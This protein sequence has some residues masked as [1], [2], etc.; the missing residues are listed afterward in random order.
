ML[1]RVWEWSVEVY[2]IW[3][4]SHPRA[5]IECGYIPEVSECTLFWEK[6]EEGGW[7]GWRGGVLYL[8][9]WGKFWWLGG[10]G[11]GL[12]G[13][14]T[15]FW[16]V[17]LVYRKIMERKTLVVPEFQSRGEEAFIRGRDSLKASFAR[18]IERRA[19]MCIFGTCYLEVISLRVWLRGGLRLLVALSSFLLR[20][21]CFDNN[22][23]EGR[24]V[25][26]VKLVLRW[27]GGGISVCSLLISSDRE[28]FENLF[29]VC[30]MS[31][32]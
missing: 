12:Q 13:V 19:P 22:D 9:T 29:Y 1:V 3:Y 8:L 15:G 16:L 32:F 11:K 27:D 21:W 30:Q 28:D 10:T 31:V 23:V 18:D 26:I 5:R 24:G 7:K 17:G 20:W 6:I 25:G 4:C 2:G 14:V